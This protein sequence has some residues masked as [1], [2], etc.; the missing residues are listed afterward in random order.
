MASCMLP[1]GD[2]LILNVYGYT[3][4]VSN[5]YL[6]FLPPILS[7]VNSL[8]KFFSLRVDTILKGLHC[9]G[10]QAG[11]HENCLPLKT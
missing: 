9:P 2:K 1:W 11:S 5:S 10:K 8:K 7:R 6:H 3:F 4:S